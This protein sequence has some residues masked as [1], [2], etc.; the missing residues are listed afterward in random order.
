MP[1]GVSVRAW[2]HGGWGSLR[3]GKAG[4]VTYSDLRPA[5]PSR[6]R[7]ADQV[8]VA[9]SAIPNTSPHTELDF[10]TI[11][12]TAFGNRLIWDLVTAP[13]TTAAT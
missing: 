10:G 8:V 3:I 11:I 2:E 5:S 9:V 7:Q 6:F 13:S 4:A 12:W 1:P